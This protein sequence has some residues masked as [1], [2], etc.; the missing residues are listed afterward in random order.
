MSESCSSRASRALGFGVLET[1]PPPPHPWAFT[2]EE[3]AEGQRQS[4][5]DTGHGPGAWTPA[6]PGSWERGKWSVPWDPAAAALPGVSR[7]A[8]LPAALG[9]LSRASFQNKDAHDPPRTP[10]PGSQPALPPGSPRGRDGDLASW[11]S[12]GPWSVLAAGRHEG[13][14]ASPHCTPVPLRPPPDLGC[15]PPCWSGGQTGPRP[16]RPGPAAGGR[17]GQGPSFR[18]GRWGRGG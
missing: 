5:G 6:A 11:D 15:A 14:G 9:T 16:A 10:H 18:R 17:P 4:H 13:A 3:E 12:G 2:V 7:P 1:V 8:H